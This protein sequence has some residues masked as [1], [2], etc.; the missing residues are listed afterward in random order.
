[1]MLAMKISRSA[2]V[3]LIA[4]IILLIAIFTMQSGED[5][6]EPAVVN[7]ETANLNAS[8]PSDSTPVATS[9]ATEPEEKSGIGAS[10]ATIEEG[11]ATSA[12][13]K[14]AASAMQEANAG[15][16][17]KNATPP[18][19]NATIEEST[20][21]V[22][23]ANGT[24]PASANPT[25]T[26]AAGICG[27][28][29]ANVLIE[30]A[31]RLEKEAAEK[32]A[33][34]KAAKEKAEKEKAEKAA[35]EKAAKEKAEKEKVEKAAKEK[36]AREKTKAEQAKPAPKEQ[37]RVAV[38]PTTPSVGSAPGDVIN[39]LVD[40]GANRVSLINRSIA[41]SKS[42]R[43]VTQE[44]GKYVG[45]YYYVEPSSLHVEASP[46]DPSSPFKYIG[47]V[48]YREGFYEIRANS[49]EEALKGEGSVIQQRNMCE[50]IQYKNNKWLE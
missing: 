32:A 31:A 39:K 18:A 44:G 17:Q 38:A 34:E 27:E 45:R 26:G 16:E 11:N 15:L 29:A 7:S 1:M 41:P 3:I 33:A 30:K 23:Q 4:V 22:T 50:L 47:K 28:R 42:S 5:A 14:E 12:G 21:A 37:P 43:Q 13:V 36:A 49:R 46:A 40:F 19:A 6:V 8:A 9:N 25:L 35:K 20:T 24:A 48:R 2:I 10:N